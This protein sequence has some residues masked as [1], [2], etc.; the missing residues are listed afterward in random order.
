MIIDSHQ[1]FWIYNPV[2][3][4]WIDNDMKRIRADFLPPYLKKVITT[5]G[6]N[7]VISVQ[8]RQTIEHTD[9]ILKHASENDF[10][11]GVV[12]WLPLI[13]K[14][15][16]DHLEKYKYNQWLK[17]LRHVLQGESDMEYML[18]DD[19]NRGI[20]LLNKY[21]LV[22]EILIFERHLPVTIKF[23]DTHPNQ[24]F[25]LNHIAKPI[26]KN[27]VI[28]PWKKNIYELAKR[29]NVFCKI[30]GMVTEAD[31]TNWT[32]EQ[33]YPYFEIILEAFD[34]GRLMFGSDWPV[35]LVACEY[36]EWFD[37]V[38]Y[39]ISRLNDSEQK[40]ILGINAQ[41]IYHLT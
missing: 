27:N 31:Y 38:K 28:E 2:E 6:V 16:E 34:P 25:I 35:C 19:F 18:H 30:S 17:G 39:F 41:R 32:V 5:A 22:Y 20:S 9:W 11:K 14:K 3:Y 4:N 24:V 10:I 1:H 13:D 33:L 26:I 37:I 29:D 8:A 15:V 36:Q 21:N 12:G 7:G 40:A 23:V